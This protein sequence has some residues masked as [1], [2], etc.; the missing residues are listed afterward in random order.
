MSRN[1]VS[2][3]DSLESGSVEK[4]LS[5]ELVVER[6]AAMEGVVVVVVTDNLANTRSDVESMLLFKYELV[7]L[8]VLRIIER[9]G[10]NLLGRWNGNDV[11][12]LN[13]VNLA[14]CSTNYGLGL[15]A[16][17]DEL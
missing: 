12:I 2:I 10:L 13:P 8:S 6:T 1:F 9:G 4:Y 7:F 11:V 17:Y 3:C 14:G 15:S 5:N 16:N